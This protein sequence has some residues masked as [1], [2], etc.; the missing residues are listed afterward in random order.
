V[1]V[2]PPKGHELPLTLSGIRTP[3]TLVVDPPKSGQS[4]EIT[5]SIPKS[6]Q[7][8]AVITLDGKVVS[9]AKN[10]ADAGERTLRVPLDPKRIAGRRTYDVTLAA[11]D[12]AKTESATRRVTL[13]KPGSGLV[14]KLAIA[15]LVLVL[16]VVVL[17]RRKRILE[18]RRRRD[19]I[20]VPNGRV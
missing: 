16:V 9:R 11:F 7:M 14:A 19:R 17:R 13:I 1:A 2:T 10:V 15:L 5:F 3:S 8:T 4:L 18:A 12:G 6:A 20:V